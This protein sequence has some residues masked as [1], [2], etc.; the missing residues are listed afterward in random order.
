MGA[1]VPCSSKP[2]KKGR[3]MRLIGNYLSPYVRRV[4][5]SLHILQMP[6]E[7]EE[8]FVFKA[9]ETVRRHNPLVRIPVLVLDDGERLVESNAI[10]DELDQLAGPGRC[11]TPAGGPERRLVVQTTAIAFACAEKAQWAFYEGR[12]RPA[13]KV[14]E[15]WIEHNERQVLGGFE[16][17]EKMASAVKTDGWLAGTRKI[18]Q[19][20]VT[21]AVAYTFAKAVRPQL[22]LLGPYPELSRFVERCEALPPFSKTPV[23]EAPA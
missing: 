13:K 16:H 23:P 19:A 5:V 7:L 15:P 4:A 21:T 10:L 12:V 3:F 20:D 17:L 2:W 14:H 6:F 22:D 8:L 11:L 1:T 18:S 9:P